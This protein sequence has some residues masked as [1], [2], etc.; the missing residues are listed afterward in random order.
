MI[1]N[2]LRSNAELV[3]MAI[4]EGLIAKGFDPIEEEFADFYV[5]VFGSRERR[6]EVTG[7][8]G[9]WYSADPYW[10]Q[11]WGRVMV[12]DYVAGTLI[13]D[14]VDA[15]TKELTWRAYCQGAVRNASKRHKVINKA[16]RKALKEFPPSR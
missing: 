6:S 11:G 13:L 10:G 8:I 14:I 2:A 15:K 4:N 7:A 5:T 12:R 3:R 9:G 16:F 1:R